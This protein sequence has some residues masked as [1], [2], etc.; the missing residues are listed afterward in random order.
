[1]STPK[2]AVLLRLDGL[3]PLLPGKLVDPF[4][5]PEPSPLGL[6]RGDISLGFLDGALGRAKLSL[7]A[8]GIVLQGVKPGC[9]ENGRETD[10]DGEQSEHGA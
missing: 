9:R 3:E 10:E 7:Q 4:R 2:P 6:E 1:M 5:T 8:T